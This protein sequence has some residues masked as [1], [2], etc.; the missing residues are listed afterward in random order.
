MADNQLGVK[1]RAILDA[2]Q[3]EGENQKDAEHQ[4][5]QMNSETNTDQQPH[6]HNHD[7]Q[8]AKQNP[9]VELTRIDADDSSSENTVTLV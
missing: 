3:R 5:M 4:Q 2:E 8:S 7:T 1:I 6:P 9:T